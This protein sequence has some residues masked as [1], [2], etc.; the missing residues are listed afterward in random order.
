MTDLVEDWAGTS[1][2]GKAGKHE[3]GGKGKEQHFHHCQVVTVNNCVVSSGDGGVGVGTRMLPTCD[4][5]IRHQA[6]VTSG[7]S[8]SAAAD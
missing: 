5:P 6:V 4:V 7:G 1:S 2:P 3:G 8:T